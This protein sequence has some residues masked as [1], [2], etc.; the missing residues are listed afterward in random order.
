[1]KPETIETPGVLSPGSR[2]RI[3]LAYPSTP[4]PI[5][6]ALAEVAFTIYLL[7]D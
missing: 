6:S 3:A 2:H 5:I 1:M 7:R 4:L